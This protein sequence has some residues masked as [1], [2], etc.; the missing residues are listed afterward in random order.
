MAVPEFEAQG[1][2]IKGRKAKGS[3]RKEE[4]E[5]V[6]DFSSSLR[7]CAVCHSNRLSLLVSKPNVDSG[8]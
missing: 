4:M 6:S 3:R 2:I 7:P 5:G 1:D 8:G